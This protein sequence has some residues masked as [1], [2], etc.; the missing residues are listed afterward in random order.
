MEEVP[1]DKRLV[2]VPTKVEACRLAA[3]VGE[4]GVIVFLGQ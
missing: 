2:F 4:K 1:I 3:E